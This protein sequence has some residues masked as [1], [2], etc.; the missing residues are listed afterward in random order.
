MLV[1]QKI[2]SVAF[3]VIIAA[4]LW[5]PIQAQT[6]S[7]DTSTKPCSEDVFHEFDFWKGEWEVYDRED[8]LVGH[9]TISEIE[10]GCALL[11]KWASVSGG[12][13][14]SY[15]FYDEVVGKWR[16]LW[17]S[18]GAVIEYSGSLSENGAM[19][20]RGLISYRG[21]N[22]RPFKG[23][24]QQDGDNVIQHFHQQNDDGEWD[25]WFYGV[26]KP[27]HKET[28]DLD[29]EE[30]ETRDEEEEAKPVKLRR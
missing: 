6:S 24:W 29:M 26:Y 9:N 12:T 1:F 30:A 8:A 5:Q 25:E 7:D 28:S 13:G 15:N 18:P 20:L 22:I 4:C 11:E 21:G 23:S 3:S 10:E 16:Q 19:E 17:V 14:Q 2:K 27:L